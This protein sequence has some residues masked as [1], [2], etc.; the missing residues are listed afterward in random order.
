MNIGVVQKKKKKKKK[1]KKTGK[2]GEVGAYRVC[3]SHSVKCRFRR[4]IVARANDR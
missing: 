4:V 1:K 3:L 2:G